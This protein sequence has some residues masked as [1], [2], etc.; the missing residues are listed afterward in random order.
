MEFTV[1]HFIF[2]ILILGYLRHEDC[3]EFEVSVGYIGYGSIRKTRT[4]E[5][6]KPVTDE[7]QKC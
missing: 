4:K 6:S 1:I 7:I 5:P 3:Y 2:I